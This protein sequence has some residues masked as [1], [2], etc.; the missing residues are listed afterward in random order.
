MEIGSA[1][2]PA[3]QPFRFEDWRGELDRRALSPDRLGGAL[4]VLTDPGQALETLHWGRDYLYTARVSGPD[5]PQTVAVKLFRNQSRRARR[6]QGRDDSKA[7]RSWRAARTLEAA[8][9]RT[10][11]PLAWIEATT[12]GGPSLYVSELL[13][14]FVESRY[15]FR[16]IAAGEEREQFPEIDRAAFFSAVGGL[17]AKVHQAGLWH[18]DLS[19]GNVL[20]EGGALPPE[21]LALIDLDRGRLGPVSRL[22]R[23]RDLCRLPILAGGDRQRFWRAY[24]GGD[25]SL[26]SPS[27]L[28]Y[29]VLQWGFLAKNRWKPRL[30][31]PGRWLKARLVQREAYAHIP[32]PPADAGARDKSVWDELS[33]QPHQHAGRREQLLIR[34]ADAGAHARAAAA[35][36]AAAPRVVASYRALAGQAQVGPRPWPGAGVALRPLEGVANGSELLLAALRRLGVGQVLLRLHPWQESHDV[37]ERLART[38]AEAGLD[39]AFALPQDRELVRDPKRWR[40]AVRLLAERFVPYGRSFQVGQ[41]INRS[42]WGIWN[43]DE[44]LALAAIA[45]EELTRHPDVQVLGPAVIDFEFQATA[46]V[47]NMASPAGAGVNFDVVTALLYVDRRGA[48]EAKQLGFDTVGKAALLKAIAATGKRSSGRCWIT[49]VNWP[50]WEGPHSPAGRTVAVDEETQADYL[51]R[52]YLATLTSGL[53]ERVY[54]WQLVARG[55][56]LMRRAEADGGGLV[57]RPAFLALAN[58]Q[59]MLAGA[60]FLERT[61]PAPSTRLYE[62]ERDRSSIFVAWATSGKPRVRLPVDRSRLERI[63]GRDGAELPLP[64]GGELEL[65]PAPV[66]L[67]ARRAAVDSSP[68]DG[69]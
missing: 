31:K 10:P 4:D 53:V 29:R 41:A 9:I 27:G 28:V 13:T 42:K 58:L 44:Y 50:L 66:Y 52:Y 69:V 43:Y 1:Q 39:L 18:R 16:A 59:A 15:Y 17:F 63:V 54:W 12:I 36:L 37:E 65:G 5:G 35:V 34:L 61:E 47:L 3:V 7:A 30:R 11:R 32:A 22:R 25:I 20:I 33:D 68:D 38:L 19:I 55:Y 67:L 48:P 46:A 40:D 57:E 6:R 62:F 56:G 8:G 60:T 14:D 21:R 24:W 49:E 45:R 64:E 26:D 23:L 51:V 2:S